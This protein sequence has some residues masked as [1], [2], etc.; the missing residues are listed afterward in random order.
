[1]RYSETLFYMKFTRSTNIQPIIM[2]SGPDF[3]SVVTF[4][5]VQTYC[6]FE[7]QI[8]LSFPVLLSMKTLSVENV[9]AK[10]TPSYKF[11]RRVSKIDLV[12]N[13]V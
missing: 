4:I 9:F 13:Y 12:G 6:L 10:S 11:S 7:I 2:R 3:V 1:M 8:F 5:F